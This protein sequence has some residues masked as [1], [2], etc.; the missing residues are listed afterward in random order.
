MASYKPFA[1]DPETPRR[2]EVNQMRLMIVPLRESQRQVKMQHRAAGLPFSLLDVA[3]TQ[4]RVCS[5]GRCPWRRSSAVAV[6]P[7]VSECCI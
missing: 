7:L 3:R 6:Q 4:I 1:L 5:A 2:L